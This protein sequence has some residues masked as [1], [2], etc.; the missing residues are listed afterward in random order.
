MRIPSLVIAAFG[1][2]VL[3]ACAA[4]PE[5]LEGEAGPAGSPFQ[6][7]S[8]SATV[9]PS[10]TVGPTPSRTSQAPVPASASRSS[11]S[12]A[13]GTTSKIRK[14]DWANVTLAGL[15]YLG[16]EDAR[17][18]NG[19]ATSGANTCTMLPG[20]ARP[21]YAEYIAEEPA[22]SPITEDALVLIE[23]GSDGLDQVLVPVKLGF[24]QK[25]RIAMGLIRAD[26]P[27]G[28]GKR[29]TFTSY[30]VQRGVIL[31][32]VRKADG[33]SEARRYRFNGGENWERF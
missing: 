25:T 1:L 5:R 11:T 21:A 18:R 22:N 12:P 13:A 31:T 2:S 33:S 9:A 17:F 10:A 32:T 26:I 6:T 30:R 20:G 23:C 8:A 28:P 7:P 24:D 29:M 3:T 16:F 15:N 27:T 19:K 4:T 14:T